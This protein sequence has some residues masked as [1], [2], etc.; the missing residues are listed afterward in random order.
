M[1]YFAL[2]LLIGLQLGYF[3]WVLTVWVREAI[4]YLAVIKQNSSRDPNV[5]RAQTIQPISGQG[6]S[7]NVVK[8]KT[9]RQIALERLKLSRGGQ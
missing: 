6:T 8:P 1:I 3:G 7:P 2:G 5:V 9:P 4:H